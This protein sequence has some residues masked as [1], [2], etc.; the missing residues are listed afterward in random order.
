MR[1]RSAA[2]H[3]CLNSLRLTASHKDGSTEGHRATPTTH[4][5]LLALAEAAL[6]APVLLLQR[7]VLAKVHLLLG[8]ATAPAGARRG[9]PA[10]GRAAR[11]CRG[12]RCRAGCRHASAAP[13]GPRRARGRCR[14]RRRRRLLL[15]LLLR[16][17]RHLLYRGAAANL[18]LLAVQVG[19]LQLPCQHSGC[20]MR[21]R[22]DW[23]RGRRCRRPPGTKHARLRGRR[24]KINGNV[25][26]VVGALRLRPK[27]FEVLQGGL[28]GMEQS[29]GHAWEGCRACAAPQPEVRWRHARCEG[30]AR[31]QTSRLGALPAASKACVFALSRQ[32][33][34]HHQEK[35]QRPGPTPWRHQC[36]QCPSVGR[37]P[38]C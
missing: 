32:Q 29:D 5:L 6:R 17:L 18:W 31:L 23:Q 35:R 20:L 25:A 26:E 2:A 38:G 21:G 27:V 34:A 8:L 4:P 28:A 24:R 1:A 22:V 11:R 13:A 10:R 3:G 7:Q 30:S 12:R 36:P 15:L 16:L 14:R 33:D 37:R 19:R 9:R